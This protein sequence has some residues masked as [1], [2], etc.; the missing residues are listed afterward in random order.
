MTLYHDDEEYDGAGSERKEKRHA[1]SPEN[2]REFRQ[3]ISPPSPAKHR[4]RSIRAAIVNL[5]DNGGDVERDRV[6]G[7]TVPR[8]SQPR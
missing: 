7:D 3:R 8:Q 6:S 1:E 4:V 2:R 5:A